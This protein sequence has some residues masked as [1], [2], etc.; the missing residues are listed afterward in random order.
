[1]IEMVNSFQ[2]LMKNPIR[3]NTRYV[4][5]FED[6][7]NIAKMIAALTTIGGGK[8]YL[9]VYDDGAKLIP[10]G[11]QFSPPDTEEIRNNLGGF[12]KFSIKAFEDNNKKY[13]L[14]S[15]EKTDHAAPFFEKYYN[16]IDEFDNNPVELFPVSIFLSYSWSEK[17]LIDLL[18]NFLEESFG[19][20]ILIF[21]D[22]QL[23]YKDN[24]TEF[25][26]KIRECDVVISVVSKSYLNSPN[27]MFEVAEFMK[28]R[29]YESRLAPIV[30]KDTDEKYFKDDEKYSDWKPE[31]YGSSRF[32][33]IVDWKKKYDEMNGIIDSIKS[34]PEL[35]LSMVN[36][37][38]KLRSIAEMIGDYMEF[39]N[40]ILGQGFSEME[41]TEF[42]GI[43]EMIETSFRKKNH[44]NSR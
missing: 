1:M 8:I 19:K 23:S 3:G 41:E 32:K 17:Q 39:L 40:K 2:E 26:K 11:Y 30:L 24:L 34:N 29:D 18:Q 12:S 44:W 15:V 42:L 33:Y 25:M 6:N 28:E 21:R 20:K 14:V 4:F 7:Q 9:G 22:T 37:S 13:V 38:R 27:C 31:V 16:F 10:K 43:R 35:S 36:D 5:P